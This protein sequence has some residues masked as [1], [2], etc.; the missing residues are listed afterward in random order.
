MLNDS[1]GIERA[2]ELRKEVMLDD[3]KWGDTQT[4]VRAG[5]GCLDMRRCSRLAGYRP[6]I[7]ISGSRINVCLVGLQQLIGKDCR[8][9]EDNGIAGCCRRVQVA[10]GSWQLGEWDEAAKFPGTLAGSMDPRYMYQSPTAGHPG[11]AGL[12]PGPSC[13]SG[14]G[15]DLSRVASMYVPEYLQYKHT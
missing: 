15:E 6:G 2:F 14:L 3:T 1:V 5:E 9:A 8:I 11:K 10:G 13:L 4:S 7:R 12:T